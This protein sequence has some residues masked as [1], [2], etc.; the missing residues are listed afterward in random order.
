MA[1]DIIAPSAS[2]LA[3]GLLTTPWLKGRDWD[4]TFF[5]GHGVVVLFL[6]TLFLRARRHWHHLVLIAFLILLTMGPDGGRSPGVSPPVRASPE[7]PTPHLP[8]TACTSSMSMQPSAEDI[9]WL[10]SSTRLT[11]KVS[12]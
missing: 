1:K 5:F 6:L 8:A 10:P 4:V 7:H 12:A 9:Q 2:N 3:R 11:S